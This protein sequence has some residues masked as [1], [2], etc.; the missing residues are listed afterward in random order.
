A[1]LDVPWSFGTAFLAQTDETPAL[2]LVLARHDLLQVL[3]WK[4]GAFV[5]GPRVALDSLLPSGTREPIF[6]RDAVVDLDNDGVD[7][8]LIPLAEGYAIAGPKGVR[9]RLEADL[10]SEMRAFGRGEVQHSLSMAATF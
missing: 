1:V 8:W 10:S 6:L 5:Y 4:E 2:E 9:T 7:E 3:H